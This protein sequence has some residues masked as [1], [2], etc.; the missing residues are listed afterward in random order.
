MVKVGALAKTVVVERAADVER[1]KRPSETY[2]NNSKTIIRE[3]L[4][5]FLKRGRGK[6]FFKRQ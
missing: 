2:N 3:E 5:A 4:P 1:K 6:G